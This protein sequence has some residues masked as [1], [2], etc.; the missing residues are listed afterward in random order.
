[1]NSTCF[2][3]KVVPFYPNEQYVFGDGGMRALAMRSLFRSM[4]A[5]GGKAQRFGLS[6][7]ADLLML[8]DLEEA[9]ELSAAHGLEVAPEVAASARHPSCARET[10]L[11]I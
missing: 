5:P 3:F 1:M 7:L 4:R 9:K 2:G 10:S 11:F 6:E 8:D